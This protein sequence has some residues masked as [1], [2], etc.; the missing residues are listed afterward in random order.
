MTTIFWVDRC[1]KT[2]PAPS[3]KLDEHQPPSATAGED[4]RDNLALNS[5]AWN[6]SWGCFPFPFPKGAEKIMVNVDEMGNWLEVHKCSENWSFGQTP[7]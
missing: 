7:I 6:L 4:H 3:K 5:A 1:I 2:I